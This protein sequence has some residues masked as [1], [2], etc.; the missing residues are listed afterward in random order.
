[1]RVEYPTSG[2]CLST[3]THHACVPCVGHVWCVARELHRHV[4]TWLAR[5]GS[6]G[7]VDTCVRSVVCLPGTGTRVW[8]RA[9]EFLSDFPRHQQDCRGWGGAGLHW[10]EKGRSR[11]PTHPLAHPPD[12]DNEDD[13]NDVAVGR[14]ALF[15]RR[16]SSTL[17]ERESEIAE[18]A[19]P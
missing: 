18:I 10:E 14:T 6:R 16:P 1:M 9:L 13:D 17:Q 11:E 4:W 15:V 19:F 2:L 12:N 8:A 7:R 3:G 5:R